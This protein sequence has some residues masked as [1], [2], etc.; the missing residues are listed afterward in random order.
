MKP[1]EALQEASE[2]LVEALGSSSRSLEA[3]AGAAYTLQVFGAGGL[4]EFG[5]ASYA[6]L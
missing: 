1:L 2:I 3:A 6:Y 5:K 4:D